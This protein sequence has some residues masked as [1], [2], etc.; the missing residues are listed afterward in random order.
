MEEKTFLQETVENLKAEARILNGKIAKA[1]E[2]GTEGTYK[3]LINALSE[4]LRL[5]ERYDWTRMYSEYRTDGVKQ[6]S[7][8]LQNGDGIIKDHKIWE[9]KE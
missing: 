9:I 1:R 2:T 3:N 8:W 6:V 5:I 7:V 4:I